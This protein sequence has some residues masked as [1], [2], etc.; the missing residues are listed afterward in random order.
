MVVLNIS[1]EPE[2]VISAELAVVKEKAK[3]LGLTAE[4]QAK[5][6]EVRRKGKNNKTAANSRQRQ[7]QDLE[8]LQVIELKTVSTE[9]Y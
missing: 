6:L 1:L 9:K 3:E 8:D 4:Q 5:V 2:F 7:I